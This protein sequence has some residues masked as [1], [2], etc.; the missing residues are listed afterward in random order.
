MPSGLPG[1][2]LSN[3]LELDSWIYHGGVMER[4]WVRISGNNKGRN[5]QK[6]KMPLQKLK[7]QAIRKRHT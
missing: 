1:A 4:K 7:R 6:I 3:D 5:L 2:L